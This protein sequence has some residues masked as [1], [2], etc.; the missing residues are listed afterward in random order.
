MHKARLNQ[1]RLRNKVQ[2]IVLLATLAL[3]LGSLAWVIGGAPFAWGTLIGLLIVFIANPVGS[4]RLLVSM[5]SARPLHL[6]EAPRLYRI[7][8]ELSR[9]AGLER[10]PRLYYLPSP[11]VNAFATGQRDDAAILISDGLLS[12]LDLRELAAVLAHETAHIA[13]GDIRVM[14]LADLLS[15]ITGLLGLFGQIL[16]ILALPALVF[17][18]EGLP[19]GPILILLAGPVLSALVQLALSRN[20]EYEADRSAVELS[21]DPRGLASALVKLERAQGPFWEQ[22][23]MP[24]RRM[25]DPSLLRSHPPTEERVRR[26]LELAQPERSG[27]PLSS[28]LILQ[29]PDPYGWPEHP[30]RR[31]PGWHLTGLWY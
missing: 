10:I 8:E 29:D 19:W 25:P 9:R 24:G 31:R 27:Q 6:E 28:R 13:N 14:T 16:L 26:L 11:V 5:Y 7:L 1:H 17:G 2:S 18:I 21:G 15:R 3:L 23:V 12:R 22:L 30:V 4:P 20:R